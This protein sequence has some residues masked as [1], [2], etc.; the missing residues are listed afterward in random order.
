MGRYFALRLCI[1][2]ATLPCHFV[3]RLSAYTNLTLYHWAM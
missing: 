1:A 3:L 2:N